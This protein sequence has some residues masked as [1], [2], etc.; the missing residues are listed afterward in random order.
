[1]CERGVDY[2]A[3]RRI[4]IGTARHDLSRFFELALALIGELDMVRQFI[5]N[6]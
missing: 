3:H 2:D 5:Q 4:I 1:M 6:E